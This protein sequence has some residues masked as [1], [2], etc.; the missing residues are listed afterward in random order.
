MPKLRG[1]S[2]H[3]RLQ[4]QAGRRPRLRRLRLQ[5]DGSGTLPPAVLKALCMYAICFRINSGVVYQSSA[6]NL[7]RFTYQSISEFSM[8]SDLNL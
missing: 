3:M 2:A 1:Q 8:P 5:R 6:L 7:L 4:V